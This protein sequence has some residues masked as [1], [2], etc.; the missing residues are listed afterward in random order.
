[1]YEHNVNDT[2][3]NYCEHNIKWSLDIKFTNS[4]LR[5]AQRSKKKTSIVA[6]D[7]RQC[8]TKKLA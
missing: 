7:E 5:G 4:T 6:I 1:M 3:G 2:S 8:K